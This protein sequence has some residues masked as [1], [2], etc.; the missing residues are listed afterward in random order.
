MSESEA[1]GPGIG[2]G[3]AKAISVSLPEGTV[4]ALRGFA[5]P[6]GVSALIAAAVEEH[7]RNRMT[8]AY[9]A[10]YEEEHGS[11]SEDEKRSAADVWARA[12]QKENRWRATG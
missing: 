11:F 4:L 2:E 10:E 8:T 12:E 3:P 7:L 9:L 5:G 1:V 6:R